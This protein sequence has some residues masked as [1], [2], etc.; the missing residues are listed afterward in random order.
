MYDIGD[1]RH[2]QFVEIVERLLLSFFLPE[3]AKSLEGDR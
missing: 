1:Q 3:K 2:H